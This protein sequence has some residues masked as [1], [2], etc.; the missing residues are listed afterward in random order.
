MGNRISV[1]AAIIT[2][3]LLIAA[4]LHAFFKVKIKN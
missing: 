3:L 1:W 2:Y 4:A